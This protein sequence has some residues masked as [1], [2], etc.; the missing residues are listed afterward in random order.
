MVSDR[1]LIKQGGTDSVLDKVER[2][3]GCY[4]FK[5]KEVLQVRL[6]AEE[7][8]TV[9]SPTLAL[10]PARCWISTDKEAL[11]VTIDCDADVNGLDEETRKQLLQIG[12]SDKDRGVFGM[13]S[14]VFEFLTGPDVDYGTMAGHR[15]FYSYGPGAELTGY[16]WNP[17]IADILPKAQKPAQEAQNR[18]LEI[19]IIEGYA[20][21]IKV[22]L[23][24]SMLGSRLEI[25]VVKNF[26]AGQ[27]D[28]IEFR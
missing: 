20:D 12:R 14:K 19:S 16:Y 4:D 8:I 6:L 7:I 25:T 11:S 2:L 24:R 1:F 13:I 23:E 10:S 26:A 28:G 17:E 3:A 21:D 22:S 18:D 27:V 15:I 9:I 5:S